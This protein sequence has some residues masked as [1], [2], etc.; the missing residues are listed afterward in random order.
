MPLLLQMMRFIAI[1]AMS[2]L[3]H[4]VVAMLLK[5]QLGLA[6]LLANLGGFL[7][8][9]AFS[10]FG[11]ARI[12]F[13]RSARNKEQF[14]RF[15][16]SA[17]SSLVVSTSLVWLITDKIG[18]DFGLSMLAVAVVVP[19]IN[20]LIMKIWVFKDHPSQ[21]LS[22]LNPALAFVVCSALLAS[23]WGR[24][25]SHDAAWYLSAT[26]KWLEG[27]ELYTRISE[28]NPPLNFYYTAPVIWLSD[29]LSISGQNSQ[30]LLI[31]V[32]TF[33]ILV[34]CQFIARKAFAWSEAKIAVFTLIVAASLIL[35]A[36]SEFAQREHLLVL[37]LMPWLL[38]KAAGKEP[39][40][41]NQFLT[42]FVG[43]LGVCLK[44]HF[45]FIPIAVT[46]L[47]VWQRR[48]LRPIFSVSNMT[49]LAV[50]L[51]YVAYVAIQHPAYFT[52]IVPIARDIYGA[53]Q[54]TVQT[55][56]LIVLSSMLWGLVI[57]IAAFRNKPVSHASLVF[58]V[59]SAGALAIYWAQGT[60]FA[61]HLVPLNTFI[62]VTAGLLVLTAPKRSLTSLVALATLLVM[63]TSHLSRGFY[64]SPDARQ[65]ISVVETTGP[66]ASM[67]VL[68]TRVDLGPGPAVEMGIDWSGSYSSNW[69][70]PGAINHLADTDCKIEPDFCTRLNSY[71]ERNR[72]DN[73]TDIL[74]GKPDLIVFDKLNRI[75]DDPDFSR[76]DF[77]SEDPRWENIMSGYEV[78]ATTKQAVF[79]R[80]KSL[81][82]I[83][84]PE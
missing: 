34:W 81:P 10:Y 3:I 77:M 41:A 20:F 11:H 28:V 60:G 24:M 68:T 52:L 25:I 17:V 35:P 9:V 5:A 65:M 22:L 45:V 42:S 2:T 59:A 48:S 74:S 14:A 43:A 40:K 67:M 64:D 82:A 55:A 63:A 80:S 18:S 12:T 36:L 38:L 53:Y 84:S 26:R 27:A 78:V 30:Y 71:L 8:A 83:T 58:L 47:D 16:V 44:P 66:I 33:L 72:N 31:S 73:I 49:F 37:L 79:L 32:L 61:Y 57:G 6:P 69:L 39:S 1:G 70:V 50:G 75:I 51:S 56:F 4:V 13:K 46:L 19:A 29:A 54:N 7:A 76:Q 21:L 15:M 23:L 62:M